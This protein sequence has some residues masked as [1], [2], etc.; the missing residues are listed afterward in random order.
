MTKEELDKIKKHLLVGGEIGLPHYSHK[1]TVD[2][3]VLDQLVRGVESLHQQL[4]AAHAFHDVAVKQR[5]AREWMLRD[6]ERKRDE[7]RAKVERERDELQAEIERLKDAGAVLVRSLER[8]TAE[9]DALRRV[10]TAAND[11]LTSLEA[12]GHRYH[13]GVPGELM[14]AVDAVDALRSGSTYESITRGDM[15]EVDE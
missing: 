15:I 1:T 12:K 10:Y 5:D 11:W 8:M 7:M 2:K 14:D 9:R 4:A 3:T 6:A 13:D